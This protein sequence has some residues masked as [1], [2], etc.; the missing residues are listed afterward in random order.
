MEMATAQPEM[1]TGDFLRRRAL[2]GMA[3][4]QRSRKD[5]VDGRLAVLSIGL[6][7]FTS[8]TK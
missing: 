2:L 5:E 7:L 6:D 1:S 4:L 8:R 3:T